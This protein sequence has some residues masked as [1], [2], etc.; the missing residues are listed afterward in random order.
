[1]SVKVQEDIANDADV[2]HT[3][4]TVGILAFSESFSFANGGF[5]LEVNTVSFSNQGASS[6]AL[7]VANFLEDVVSRSWLRS[8]GANSTDSVTVTL[9]NEL[10]TVDTDS[11]VSDNNADTDDGINDV[12][13]GAALDSSLPAPLFWNFLEWDETKWQ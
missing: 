2:G 13:D 4:E 10:P 8:S 5:P 1:M 7:T 11:D 9:T 12:D 6:L 3:S